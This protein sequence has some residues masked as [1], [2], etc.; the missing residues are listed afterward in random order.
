MIGRT[1]A[2]GGGGGG[3]NYKIVGGT[4]QP[5]NPRENTIW[6]KTDAK[7]T[8][9]I[10]I[11][12]EP[13]NPD[14]GMVWIKV[15]EESTVGFNA[16]KKNCIVVLPVAVS[17]YLEGHWVPLDAFIYQGGWVH[18]ANA[19]LY[20]FNKGDMCVDVS[21]GWQTNGCCTGST[22]DWADPQMDTSNG[23][24]AL[25]MSTKY[26]TCGGSV[27]SV[28]K[29]DLTNY[30]KLVFDVSAASGHAFYLGIANPVDRIFWPDKYCSPTVG[31]NTIDISGVSGTYTVVITVIAASSIPVTLNI[32]SIYLE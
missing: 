20:L 11:K 21:G 12:Q 30:N 1:N 14:E 32:D 26:N 3:L 10:F 25:S 2:G 5:G 24:M 23:T 22:T 8:S 17:Q 9:H 29:I 16:L 15:G 27:F 13:N 28:N 18:F 4:T 19:V 31:L 6:V 7:I